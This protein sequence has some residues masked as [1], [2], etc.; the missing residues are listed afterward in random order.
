MTYYFG[1]ESIIEFLTAL[2]AISTIIILWKYKKSPEV[3]YL[4]YLEFQVAIWAITYAFEFGTSK[5]ETKVLWSQLSYFG[6]AFLPVCYFLF[7][8]AFSQKSNIITRRNV[9]LL[10]I[11]PIITLILALTNNS[12][13]LIWTNVTLDPTYN[14]A[15]YF[16]G[17]WFWI[18]FAYT[19]ILIFSGLYNLVVSIYKFTAFYKSQIT[20]LLVGSFFPMFGNLLYVTG[21]NPYPGFDWTPVSF[22]ATGII[23]TYGIVRYR[24]FDLVPLARNKLIDTMEDGV[25]IVNEESYVEDCNKVIYEIFNFNPKSTIIRK[26][27]SDIFGGYEVLKEGIRKG[28]VERIY[29]NIHNNGE[30]KNY[31]VR[32]SPIYISDKKVAGNL[33][34]FHDITY[35]K[36]AEDELKEANKKLIIEIKQ[37]EKLIDDLDSFAHTVAHDLKNSLGSIVAS[38]D[39]MEESINDNETDLA[40][41]LAGLIKSSA[42]KSLKITQELLILATVSHQEISKSKLDMKS[43]FQEAKSQLQDLIYSKNAKIIEPESWPEAVGYASWVEE[44]WTNYLSNAMKY[45]G[46]PP[47]IEVGADIMENNRVRFWIKDNGDGVSEQQQSKLFKKHIRLDPNKA[48]GYGLGLSIIKR[49]AEKLGGIVGV[50]SLGKP[51]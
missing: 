50:E 33:L 9:I 20:T 41:E 39:V 3:K 22:I 48:E 26:P 28:S 38:C 43:I 31:Q 24:M 47:E 7:T 36:R 37:R 14:I 12:H 13:H 42:S 49:I 46:I 5:L 23:V 1:T 10:S 40:T 35:V 2:A 29:I 4:M 27:F 8:T 15:H 34:I 6:I 19:Q 44:I 51:G 16:H 17:S 25:I 45:G 32:I 21:W 30:K 11:I 18:F